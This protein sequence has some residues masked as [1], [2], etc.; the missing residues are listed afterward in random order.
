MISIN[1]CRNLVLYLLEKNN[2]G[3]ITPSAFD[4]FCGLAQMELFEDLFY[5]YNKWVLNQNRRLT[6][7]EFADIPKNIREQI[8]VFSEYS[9]IS[10]FTYDVTDEVWKFTDS[11]LYRA[12]GLSLVNAQG[13]KTDI[14][15]VIKGSELNNLINSTINPPTIT[16]PI[17][18]KTGP[19]FKVYPVVQS[20]F[21]VE[22]LYIRT[23]KAPKWTYTTVLGNPVYNASASDKQDIE[24]DESM[25]FSFIMKVMAYCGVS[26]REQDIVVAAANAEAINE[27][28]QS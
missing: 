15:E 14:E 18:V 20:G 3:F 8:D 5:E 19:G 24:L 16:Y 12:I 4:A 21:K 6:N 25:F 17:Y 22:L 9:T 7:T 13:R 11:D 28:K 26:L 1:K 27:Q 10:N 23:P 2:R